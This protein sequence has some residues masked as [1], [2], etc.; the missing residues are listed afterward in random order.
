MYKNYFCWG[1]IFLENFNFQIFWIPGK[2]SSS[3][4]DGSFNDG[5]DDDTAVD[6][7]ITN[8]IFQIELPAISSS[9]KQNASPMQVPSLTPTQ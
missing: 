2:E 6:E 3:T 8:T 5:V 7:E 4:S 1:K 9:P